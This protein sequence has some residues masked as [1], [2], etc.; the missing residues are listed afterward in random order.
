MPDLH[1]PVPTYGHLLFAHALIVVVGVALMSG[2][3]VAYGEWYKRRLW[4][5]R[6]EAARGWKWL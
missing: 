4:R 2:I 5:R 1:L 3:L 6:A